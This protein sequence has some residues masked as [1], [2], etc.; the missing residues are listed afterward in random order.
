MGP[1]RALIVLGTVLALAGCADTGNDAG[2]LPPRAAEIDAAARSGAGVPLPG[3]AINALTY[4]SY[5]RA[6]FLVPAEGTM[7]LLPISDR[8]KGLRYEDARAQIIGRE[9]CRTAGAPSEAV[10]V[11][12]RV[13][14]GRRIIMTF[15]RCG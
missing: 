8:E 9:Y 5:T 2:G 7:T 6:F 13:D 1:T 14:T 11:S 12:H 10:E 4:T 3:G 15:L